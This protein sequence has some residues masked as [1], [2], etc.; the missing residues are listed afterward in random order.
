MLDNY[1]EINKPSA[2]EQR[3]ER[4]F[5]L[6]ELQNATNKLGIKHLSFIKQSEFE[7]IT[8]NSNISLDFSCLKELV[9]NKET[10]NK[11]KIDALWKMGALQTQEA[12]QFIIE[13]FE[14]FGVFAIQALGDTK[15]LIALDFLK[16]QL[17]QLE[18]THVIKLEDQS[19]LE[20]E[21]AYSIAKLDPTNEGL[22]L[23]EHPF[24]EVRNGATL[25]IGHFANF[26]IFKAL[27]NTFENTSLNEPI[28]RFALYRAIDVS[29]MTLET[30]A[31]PEDVEPLNKIKENL[32]KEN[33]PQTTPQH[34][35]IKDR[36]EWTINE[37]TYR[38]KNPPEDTEPSENNNIEP[39]NK[40]NS[41]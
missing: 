40:E 33:L 3:K 18:K 22:K 27:L 11:T 17:R 9:L 41:D 16:G 6:N 12:T 1:R 5:K 26:N 20:T 15:Q 36:L 30:N 25:G 34:K 28:K 31:K 19:Y 13:H 24:V 23:L 4:L 29:L 10:T 37:I 21:V 14:E 38:L 7:K 32:P 39:S 8:P 2:P 35:A